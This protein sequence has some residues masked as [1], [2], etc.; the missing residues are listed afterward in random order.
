[1]P[2]PMVHLNIA[3]RIA[4]SLQMQADRNSFYLGNIA[5]DSIHMREGTTREDKEYTHFNPTDEGDYVGGLKGL[6]LTYMQQRTDEGWKW[7]VRGYFIHVMTDYY[8][9]RSVHP[10]FVERVN[11]ADLSLGTSK[12]KEELARLYYQ[13]TDQID[14]NLYQGTSWS[15]EVW[16]ML[17]SSP[18]Y[19]MTDRLTADEI[20]RWRDHTFSFLN[21]EEPGITPEFITGEKIRV[22][23]EETVQRL[24]AL[25]SSWDPA[26]RN[27][28]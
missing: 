2:L 28:I 22:F 9:F 19:D 13:E 26:L 14:F 24:I 16:Q 5:P 1:M 27:W 3:N 17:N 20:V 11:K 25:L 4:D 15:E 23:V 8:W 7:F 21:G 6:Y 10:E 18:G 12:S